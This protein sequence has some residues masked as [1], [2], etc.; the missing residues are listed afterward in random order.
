MPRDQMHW[1][2]LPEEVR[3]EAKADLHQFLLLKSEELQVGGIPIA[4]IP[5]STTILEPNRYG[6]LIRD[7]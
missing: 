2:R 3:D 1:E 4:P 7:L 5:L 6:E